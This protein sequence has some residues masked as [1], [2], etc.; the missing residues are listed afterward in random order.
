MEL[1]AGVGK[2][3]GVVGPYAGGVD[4]LPD[5]HLET[6]AGL[7]VGHCRAR[8]PLALPQEA[9]DLD[10]VGGERAEPGGGP[11]HG[12]RVPGVIHLGVPVL[13]GADAGLTAYTRRMIAF[14]RAHP[15][16][17]RGRY[18]ADPGYVIWFTP[19]GRAMTDADWRCSGSKSLAIHVDGTVAPDLDA[20][21][22]PMLDDDLLILVNGAPQPVTFT[23]PEVGKPCSWRA[24]IDSF[25][26]GADTAKSHG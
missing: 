26:L 14:R 5:A 23:L 15:A 20:R 6:P 7:Q 8:R 1:A 22:R 11:H 12:Q 25:D 10:P 21:G 13:H 9:G 24:E 16:L 18:L 17:R 4:D 19:A 2:S 3:L